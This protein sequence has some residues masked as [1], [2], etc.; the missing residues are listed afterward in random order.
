MRRKFGESSKSTIAEVN[1]DMSLE[2]EGS[3][4]EVGSHKIFGLSKEVQ[5][6]QAEKSELLKELEEH[7]FK[8]S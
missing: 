4:D 2:D 1:E 3:A 7:G 5:Q 8:N 6:L